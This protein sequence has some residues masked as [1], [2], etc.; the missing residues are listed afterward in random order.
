MLPFLPPF[1]Q[2]ISP[3]NELHARRTDSL[4]RQ[5]EFLL[6]ALVSVIIFAFTSS[7]NAINLWNDPD[8][9]LVH[10]NGLGSDILGGAVKRDDSANDSLYFKFQVDPQ[11]DKDTEEYFAAFELFEGNS[12]RMGVG[13]ALK[14]WAYSAFFRT[15]D[16]LDSNSLA[17]YID[18]HSAKPEFPS[19]S[20]SGSYQYPRRGTSA[21]IVFKIQYI[22]G[23]DD[24]ITVWL[25]PDLGPGANE[26]SQAENLTTRFN[27]NG[28]FNE[29]RLRHGGR[30]G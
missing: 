21:T 26:A 22:P 19:G 17:F 12:E 5:R 30:G 25:D 9:T 8:S 20:S 28:S 3:G 24:L 13:N 4:N 15:S 16:A 6:L 1:L 27:A 29:I 11:S 23:A 7:A 14:A 2:S 10:E 18:L